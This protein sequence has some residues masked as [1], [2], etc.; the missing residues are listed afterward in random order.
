M[1]PAMW[2]TL[3]R[4]R[5]RLG[6]DGA[7]RPHAPDLDAVVLAAPVVPDVVPP[8]PVPRPVEDTVIVLGRVDVDRLRHALQQALGDTIEPPNTPARIEHALDLILRLAEAPGQARV[9]RRPAGVSTPESWEIH[10]QGTDRATGAAVR[11]AGRS[12]RFAA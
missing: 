11:E 3:S 9:L 10:L 1:L 5:R 2:T 4:A 12:G 8:M 7:A 6:G